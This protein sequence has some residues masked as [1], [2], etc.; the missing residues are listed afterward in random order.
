MTVV[1]IFSFKLIISHCTFKTKGIIFVLVKPHIDIIKY[2]DTVGKPIPS[3]FQTK[4][5]GDYVQ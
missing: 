2:S 4:E 5:A 1:N 3:Q